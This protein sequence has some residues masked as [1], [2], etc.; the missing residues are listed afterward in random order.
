M[1]NSPSA[2]S[3]LVRIATDG[4]LN[5]LLAGVAITLVAW[6]VTQL[7]GRHGSGTRFAVWFSALVAITFLPWFGFWRG[8]QG[9]VA[10]NPSRGA[11]MLP[12]SFA[13]YLFTVWM[14]GAAFGLLRIGSGLSRLRKLRS[15][16]TPVDLNRLNS[17]LCESLAE[18]QSRRRVTLWSSD[19][20]RVPAALGYFRPIVVVPT[21]ALQELPPGELDA[22]LLHELA[23]LRRWD[24]WTNLAQKFVKAILFFHPAVWF[25]ESRLSLE[26]EMACD[27]A[28]LAADFS[29]RAYAESLL[30]LAEKSF[31][32]R[33]VQ[34]AQA[35][36]SHVHQLKARV[37]EIMR[38]DRKGSG[39]VWTPAVTLMAMAGIISIYSTSRAPQLFTVSSNES[40]QSASVENAS[41]PP[42]D[43]RLGPVNLSR[44]D[45]APRMRRVAHSSGPVRP[46]ITRRVT[47][48][49]Q[50]SLAR[51]S[52]QQAGFEDQIAA[53]S[54]TVLSDFAASQANSVPSAVLVV[55]QGEQFGVDGPVL[56]RLTIVRLTRAQRRAIFGG[57]PKQ[58]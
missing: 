38:K 27:D 26:R 53:A 41:S 42:I 56:W 24:D 1:L 52:A 25:I 4:I 8:G 9:Q 51:F 34:L 45:A 46:R 7:F 28:V 47:P 5:S 29:P 50:I 11:V 40:Q 10:S 16:C 31:L 20:V 54:L 21:W 23:H 14:I 22:I 17:A 33:G 15:T 36:V 13:G 58:I 12:A 32:R 44:L 3:T 39:R 35:A 49:A 30:G 37:V 18:I 57:I 55:M 48:D 43:S 2:M 6:A 19:A